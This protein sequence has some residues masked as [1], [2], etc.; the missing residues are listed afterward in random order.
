MSWGTSTRWDV[1]QLSEITARR[2]AAIQNKYPQH[3]E[4]SKET[5]EPCLCRRELC[6]DTPAGE[7]SGQSGGQRGV[8]TDHPCRKE[9]LGLAEGER[10]QSAEPHQNLTK[11]LRVGGFC[12]ALPMAHR[13][14]GS[15]QGRTAVRQGRG[16]HAAICTC[17]SLRVKHVPPDF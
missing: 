16:A 11:G 1:T 5:P 2:T 14:L 13:G 3:T 8:G 6:N 9:A 15:S 17:I 4:G 10:G 12:S 7:R